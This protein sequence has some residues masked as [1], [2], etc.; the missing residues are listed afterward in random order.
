[1]AYS[2]ILSASRIEEA[3]WQTMKELRD[4][5]VKQVPVDTG[6]LRNAKIR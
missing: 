3:L 5:A 1:M 2:D 4:E 6:N